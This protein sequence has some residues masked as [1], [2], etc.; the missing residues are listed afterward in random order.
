MRS[1]H[2]NREYEGDEIDYKKL[3]GSAKDKSMMPS[4]SDI[5]CLICIKVKYGN[6]DKDR[7]QRHD[8]GEVGK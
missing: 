2:I 5:S 4:F 7:C 1:I 3:Y 8:R 6:G